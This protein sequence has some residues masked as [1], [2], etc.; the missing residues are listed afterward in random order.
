MGLKLR[1]IDEKD[2]G[3][4]LNWRM[5]PEVTKYMYTDPQL[6]MDQQK[7]WFKKIMS[8]EKDIYWI[9]QMDGVDIG[10]ISITEIDYRNGRCYW[11]Y[12]IA[13]MSFRGRGVAIQLECNVYDYAFERLKLHKVC[14]EVFCF[15]EK[16]I[17][18]HQKLGAVI[19]GTRKEHIY[20]D[21]QYFDIVQMGMDRD[22]WHSIRKNYSYDIALFDD[23]FLKSK[24]VIN[25]DYSIGQSGI[26]SK[27]LTESDVA[28]FAGLSGDFNS[29]H[30]NAI[31]AGKSV[32]GKR[33]CHGM[34]VASYISTV[35]GNYFPGKGT[36][37]LSQNMTFKKPV[38]IGDTI[39]AQ[40]MVKEI[41]PKNV[42]VL[43][44]N[45]LNQN[46][47]IVISGEAAVKV[48]AAKSP[49]PPP[50]VIA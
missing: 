18:I 25:S 42:L 33:I 45:V 16:V 26:F 28:I 14:C 31:E 22:T 46:E 47:E 12:Y 49:P 20:K 21:G 11:A 1:Q 27:T 29:L 23:C 30:M 39:T 24:E 37:Y 36:I 13:D 41:K 17:L 38:Y 34:L 50:E 3:M 32:F 35:L 19:E 44:T 6:T 2:L 4:I 9:I 40:V 7:Q 10:V 43:E 5:M 8:S 15:N 48:P